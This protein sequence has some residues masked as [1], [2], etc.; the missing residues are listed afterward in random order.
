MQD[1]DTPLEIDNV[2]LQDTVLMD[3]DLITP[4]LAT[5]Q[6]HIGGH[7]GS[8]YAEDKLPLTPDDLRQLRDEINETLEQIDEKTSGL[9]VDGI[10][11][12]CI[13]CGGDI[14]YGEWHVVKEN[15]SPR[16]PDNTGTRVMCGDKDGDQ[17]RVCVDCS[18]REPEDFPEDND[19]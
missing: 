2:E 12:Q 7:H 16:V 3:G 1:D 4:L 13:D 18:D 15:P 6:W 19:A 9:P 17:E 8:Q 10:V 14:A 11:G 5:G